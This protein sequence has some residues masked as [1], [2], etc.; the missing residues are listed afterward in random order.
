MGCMSSVSP[1]EGMRGSRVPWLAPAAV[2]K[3]DKEDEPMNGVDEPKW[4]AIDDL[5]RQRGLVGAS[6]KAV[7]DLA[8]VSRCA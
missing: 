4:D 6:G 7:V 1:R 8:L 2:S 3:Q 5:P